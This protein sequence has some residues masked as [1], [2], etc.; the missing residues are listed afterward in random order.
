M[1]GYRFI[2]MYAFIATAL[3]SFLVCRCACSG[4]SSGNDTISVDST[5]V[6]DTVFVEVHDT[7]PQAKGET[8][9][10]YITI[11][12]PKPE[13]GTSD[14]AIQDSLP[15]V[16]I[17]LPVVQKVYSDD[18]TY[19]AYVSGLKHDDLPKLDSII[20]RQRIITNTIEKVI[21]IQKKRSRWSVGL[22][23]GYGFGMKSR[24]FEP[25]VGIGVS[26]AIIP[27]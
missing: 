12:A 13:T 11:Q 8:I 5:F 6:S 14:V 26:Y 25:Y 22:Q 2:L 16:G 7:L 17:T 27:P 10:K 15:E 23:G 9:I 20:T 4:N 18:S 21:T 19:T 1:K 3:L 24:Q